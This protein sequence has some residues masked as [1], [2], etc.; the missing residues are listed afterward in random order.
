[1]VL[2]SGYGKTHADTFLL[3]VDLRYVQRA[4]L[5]MRQPMLLQW[6][7]MRKN[8]TQHI[9][10]RHEPQILKNKSNKIARGVGRI[11]SP[12]KL[13]CLRPDIPPAGPRRGSS[14][15]PHT[16]SCFAPCAAWVAMCSAS[17][18]QMPLS[19]SNEEAML[20]WKRS[21][22]AGE[23]AGSSSFV[24]MPCAVLL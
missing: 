5:R 15:L 23:T 9:S 18:A 2:P 20:F 8:R 24:G 13:G 4:M 22:P 11:E 14:I 10:T 6:K 21:R 16:A 12:A 1:M 3:A 7:I 17:G 19:S